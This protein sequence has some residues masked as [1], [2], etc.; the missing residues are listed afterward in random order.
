M[1]IKRSTAYRV[2]IVDIVTNQFVKQE[3]FNPSYIEFDGNQISRVN[4]IST[5]VGK[6]TSDDENYSALT[7]DDGTE[8]IR[9]KGFGPEVLRLKS[10]NVGQI[11]RLIGKVK[12]YNDEKYLTC[13]AAL[14]LEPNW[15][16]VNELELGKHI[17]SEAKVEPPTKT[18]I[19][20][21]EE[22]VEQPITS[23]E[24]DNPNA[25]VLNLIR[26]ED[27]GDGALMEVV[28]SKSGMSE[29]DAK[30]VLFALL[31]SGEIF[32]PKKGILKILD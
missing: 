29:E 23:S 24:S 4:L 31:K 3:G 6:Y 12:Q 17:P 26:S 21:S 32:E 25:K 22:S 9:V 16:I 15:L 18:G 30:S 1:A 28:I 10:V 5:V 14:A 20:S 11:V 19:S 2:R 7:L 13:E 27:K 8:T